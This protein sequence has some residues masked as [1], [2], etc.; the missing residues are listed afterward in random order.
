MLSCMEKIDA[1][2]DRRMTQYEL[3]KKGIPNKEVA[4]IVGVSATYACTIYQ[5]Y[6]TVSSKRLFL[7]QDSFL[8][9]LALSAWSSCCISLFSSARLKKLCLRSLANIQ[10]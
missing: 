8:N 3:R 10:R 6:L 2:I 5:K 7:L 9:G 1:R 4:E